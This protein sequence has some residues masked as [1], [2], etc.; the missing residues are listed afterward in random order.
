MSAEFSSMMRSAS[1]G[2][3][4]KMSRPPPDGSEPPLKDIPRMVPLLFEGPF[5]TRHV[6][7]TD[8]A[9]KYVSNI[10]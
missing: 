8:P 3:Q 10:T 1:V 4:F 2:E 9:A 5:S 6:P 7:P